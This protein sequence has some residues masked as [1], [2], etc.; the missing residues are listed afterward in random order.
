MFQNFIELSRVE[1]GVLQSFAKETKYNLINDAL[2]QRTFD[3][4]GDYY[5]RPFEVFAKESLN[6]QTDESSQGDEIDPERLA[7]TLEHQRDFF[8][9]FIKKCKV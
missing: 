6:D 5:I 7:E 4:S 3:E 1:N 8:I 9:K 2:A